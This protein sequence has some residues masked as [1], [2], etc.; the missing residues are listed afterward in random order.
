MALICV[1][2]TERTASGEGAISS[3]KRLVRTMKTCYQFVI[4]G[5]D[6]KEVLWFADMKVSMFPKAS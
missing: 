1:L 2:L 6:G 5:A 3:R 4:K